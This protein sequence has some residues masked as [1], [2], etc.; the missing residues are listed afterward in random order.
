MLVLAIFFFMQHFFRSRTFISYFLFNIC[1]FNLEHG[2][3][4]LKRQFFVGM[5]SFEK[6][7]QQRNKIVQQLLSIQCL[8]V[9]IFANQTKKFLYGTKNVCKQ[10]LPEHLNKMFQQQQMFAYKK[11]SCSKKNNRVLNRTENVCKE[12]LLKLE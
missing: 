7:S 11:F 8:R 9:N 1:F 2:K 5:A 10:I 6:F 12:M 3:K 4:V